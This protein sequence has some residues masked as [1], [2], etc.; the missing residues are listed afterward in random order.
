LDFGFWILDFRLRN[1][2]LG[3]VSEID[4]PNL[5]FKWVSVQLFP[6]EGAIAVKFFCGKRL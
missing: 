6:E 5:Q 3:V 2:W 1:A 4:L